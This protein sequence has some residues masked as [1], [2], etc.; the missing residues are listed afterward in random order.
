MV[1]PRVTKLNV[2]A[3]LLLESGLDRTPQRTRAHVAATRRSAR[4]HAHAHAD[5][6]TDTDQRYADIFCALCVDI[7]RYTAAAS[8]PLLETNMEDVFAYRDCRGGYH[9]LTHSTMPHQNGN[10]GP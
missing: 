4:E 8:T 1:A 10:V 7:I 2:S 3:W 5:T 6:N 9:M